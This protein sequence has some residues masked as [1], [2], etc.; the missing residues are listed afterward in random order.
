MTQSVLKP[1][2]G[3]GMKVITGKLFRHHR[4]NGCTFEEAPP[5]SPR[6]PVRR[7][8]RVALMLA[9]AHKIQDA[10]DRAV[11]R[12]RAEVAERLGVTRARVSQLMDLTLLAPTIQE[13]ILFLEAVDGVEPFSER[14]LRGVAQDVGWERQVQGLRWK[15]LED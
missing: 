10:I 9:L 4:G 3:T 12:D 5:A 7:P 6:V 2:P 1:D 11:V 15:A 8:A 14:V 13:R